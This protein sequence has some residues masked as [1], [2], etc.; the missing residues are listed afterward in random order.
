MR[1]LALEPYYDGSHKA[2]IDGWSDRSLHEFT[3]LTLPARKW[4][5]RMRHSAITFADDLNKRIAEGEAWDLLFCSSMLN[6]AE[7]FGLAN[8]TIRGLPSVLYFHENQLTYPD[9]HRKERDMHFVLTNVTSALAAT[10][11]WFNSDFHRHSFLTALPSFF[12]RMP[13]YTPR[14]VA[15]RIDAKSKVNPQ[16]IHDFGAR[17]YTATDRPA[18]LWAARWENDKNP[19]LFFEAL[20]TIRGSGL[21]FRLNVVG[22]QFER[23]PDVF[24]EARELFAD[25]I[26]RW[27]YQP[28]RQEYQQALLESDIFVSTADHEFFGITAA[29]AMSAGAYPLLPNRLAYPELLVSDALPDPESFLYDNAPGQISLR[30]TEL[31]RRARSGNLW[32]D[33]SL[34]CR[35]AV[36]RFRWEVVSPLLDSEIARLIQQ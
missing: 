15:E 24:S 3:L 26:D 4:K 5:W 9:P 18:I 13:D 20:Q 1:I 14:D 6:L 16:G 23:V 12:N 10:E 31:I 33:N 27:G 7:F 36:A 8:E 22:Q 21:P 28:N 29:E 17:T 11:V 30:L 34:R 32:G 25:C 19:E 35:A 2:F